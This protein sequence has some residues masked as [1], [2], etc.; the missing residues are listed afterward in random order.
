[1]RSTAIPYVGVDAKFT[2]TLLDST[3]TPTGSPI[4]LKNSDWEITPSNAI[5]EAPNTTDGMLRAPGLND[6]KVTA[7]GSTDTKTTST[8]IEAE[9]MPGMIVAFNAY[10]SATASTSFS[11]F[12]II[13]A[14]LK[15]STGTG[16]VEN[17]DLSGAKAF[18]PLTLPNGSTF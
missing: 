16:T 12:I 3:G 17:W 15:I 11:G 5:A 10:R 7:K 18:G 9:V 4:N 1:M 6:Y 13:G 14:D 8:S 2:I